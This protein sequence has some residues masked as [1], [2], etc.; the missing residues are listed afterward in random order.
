MT[1]HKLKHNSPYLQVRLKRV[2]VKIGKWKPEI[3][4]VQRKKGRKWKTVATYKSEN[5]A[6]DR[7]VKIAEQI[8]EEWNRREF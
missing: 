3:I 5:K 2:R 1:G 6:V 8:R 7:L 4:N